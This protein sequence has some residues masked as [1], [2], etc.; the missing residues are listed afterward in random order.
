MEKKEVIV[1]RAPIVGPQLKRPS[2]ETPLVTLKPTIAEALKQSIQ[3]TT[4]QTAAV[5]DGYVWIRSG[6]H[7]LAIL[8]TNIN[9]IQAYY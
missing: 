4:Q 8:E 5:V 1:V 9:I 3:N 7:K 6:S 2:F